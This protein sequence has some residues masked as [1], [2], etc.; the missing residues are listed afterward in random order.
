MF[1]LGKYECKKTLVMRINRIVFRLSS[2]TSVNSV[3]LF[4]L[5]SLGGRVLP[6]LE[7]DM[8]DD[9]SARF[10]LVSVIF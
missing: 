3:L 9:K 6:S 8:I 4:L 1:F 2:F 7:F 5:P 10:H